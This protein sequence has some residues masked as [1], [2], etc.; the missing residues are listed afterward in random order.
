MHRLTKQTSNSPTSLAFCQ[1]EIVLLILIQRFASIRN[2]SGRDS[3][4]SNTGIVR[5]EESLFVKH[6]IN[7]N[8]KCTLLI[9]EFFF[10]FLIITVTKV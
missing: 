1:K 5:I 10:F 9:L 8:I 6:N 7:C 3:A 2:Y 4:T